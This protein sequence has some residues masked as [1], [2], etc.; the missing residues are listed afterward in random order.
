MGKIMRDKKVFLDPYVQVTFAGQQ[1]IFLQSNFELDILLRVFLT[2]T[3]KQEELSPKS[4]GCIFFFDT[5]LDG[6]I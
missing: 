6:T 5:W 2:Q 1:V 3:F 4:L